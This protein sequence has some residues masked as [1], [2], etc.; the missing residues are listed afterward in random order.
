MFKEII[1]LMKQGLE[2]NHGI[3]EKIKNIFHGSEVKIISFNELK[4][5]NL[6]NSD[7]V[8]TLGG[9]GTFV[10]A[11]NIIENSLILGINA[12]SE[13]SEGALTGLDVSEIERLKEIAEGNYDVIERT[14]AK[15]TLNGKVLEE[16]ALNEVYIGAVSQFH[17][18]RYK[19][20]FK[21]AEEEHRSSGVIIST[22]TGSPAWFYS[23][24]GEIF[25]YHEKKL[26]FIVREP[27]FGKRVFTPKIL[28]GHIIEGEKITIKSTRHF[29]GIL[30]INDSTYDFNEGDVAEIEIS[31]KPL[32]V[33]KLR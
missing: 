2:I 13:K 28:K 23:A 6:M 7:F 22:G 18:S 29:G 16:H 4:K 11:G 15:I 32:R 24:G 27:Y 14:R 9:D 8:I 31:D 25:P 17:S 20:K 3:I 19:I 30:A 21:D 26:G 10:R 5:T 1:V 12:E 33:V